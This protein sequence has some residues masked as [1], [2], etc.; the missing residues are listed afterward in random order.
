M[1]VD[2]MIA[3]IRLPEATTGMVEVNR[4]AIQAF[5]F[6]KVIDASRLTHS[7]ISLIKFRLKRGRSN[8]YMV[9]P[10]RVLGY[11]W[12]VIIQL[13]V[14]PELLILHCHNRSFRLTR[15]LS[16]LLSSFSR[17]RFIY[18]S[19]TLAQN[20]PV[21]KFEYRIVPNFSKFDSKTIQKNEDCPLKFGYVG[22]LIS[23]KGYC[24]IFELSKEFSHI[25]FSVVGKFPSIDEK[26]R[27]YS[28]PENLE[29][30]KRIN[31][32]DNGLYGDKLRYHYATLDVLIFPTEYSHEA[33]PLVII[34]ALSQGCYILTTSIGGIPD[35][36]TEEWIGKCISPDQLIEEIA[37]L[38]LGDYLSFENR[39]KRSKHAKKLYSID[40]FKRRFNESLRP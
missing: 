19:E 21:D 4:M 20:H 35:I 18:L 5:R 31:W 1:G 40:S 9:S 2:K 37:L 23:E 29:K 10:V 30:I 32:N 25:S 34:E 33:F 36:V 14:Q 26:E 12:V 22:N 39:L 11:L 24:K 3:L 15:S 27:F 6:D 17:V 16:I 8:V 7:I 38:Q 13:T 28:D